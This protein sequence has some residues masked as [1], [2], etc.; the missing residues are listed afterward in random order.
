[1]H[2]CSAVVP[3]WPD[4]GV[5]ATLAPP[6]REPE[7]ARIARYTTTTSAAPDA[8]ASAA[9]VS[10]PIDPPPPYGIR[11]QNLARSNPADR[12]TSVSSE[13]STVYLARPSPPAREKPR[14][15]GE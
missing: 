7:R 8:I 12:T 9:A 6:K 3:P 4:V 14:S 2:H 11:A 13:G 10:V 1:M 15:A 5:A